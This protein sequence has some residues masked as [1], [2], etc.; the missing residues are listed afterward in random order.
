MRTLCDEIKKKLRKPLGQWS[1][2]DNKYITSWQWFLS[3]DLHILY[4]RAHET[5]HKNKRPPSRVRRIFLFQTDTKSESQRPSRL[6]V[7]RISLTS[8]TYTHLQIE[9]TGMEFYPDP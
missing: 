2:D 7:F 4:Y 1:L 6:Q 3:S 8:I 5:W 9:A